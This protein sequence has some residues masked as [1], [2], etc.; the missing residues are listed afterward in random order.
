MFKMEVLPRYVRRDIFATSHQT[1]FQAAS[2][3]CFHNFPP[4]LLLLRFQVSVWL[5]R[6]EK[7]RKEMAY[8]RMCFCV[9][10]CYTR[11][12]MYVCISMTSFVFC[13]IA[14]ILKE[15]KEKKTLRSLPYLFPAFLIYQK[16][17]VFMH[18]LLF[19]KQILQIRDIVKK[20]SNSREHGKIEEVINLMIKFVSLP[21]EN[22]RKVMKYLSS[23]L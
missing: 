5:L 22:Q 20:L 23:N 11:V 10:T 14:E 4:L 18:E 3:V 15:R 19:S 7:K 1:R 16:D 17:E 12:S 8:E 13:L 21:E 2:Q 6:K 9:C